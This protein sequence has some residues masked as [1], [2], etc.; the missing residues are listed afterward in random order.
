MHSVAFSAPLNPIMISW[1]SFLCVTS[2]TVCIVTSG[3]AGGVTFVPWIT[4]IAVD[5][6]PSVV[7]DPGLLKAR[8]TVTPDKAPVLLIGITTV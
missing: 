1:T 2:W 4:S 3:T 7:L 6:L 5:W 8:F